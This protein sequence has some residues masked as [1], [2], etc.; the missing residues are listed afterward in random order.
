MC[1]VTPCKLREDFEW[2]KRDKVIS[3][4]APRWL[5]LVAMCQGGA[6]G[7]VVGCTHSYSLFNCKYTLVQNSERKH[8]LSS[9]LRALHHPDLFLKAQMISNKIEK[10]RI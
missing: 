10:V 3:Q 5:V 6:G 8:A 4:Y 9:P 7:G 1:L 2:T